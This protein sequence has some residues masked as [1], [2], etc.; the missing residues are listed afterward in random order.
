MFVLK[1]SFENNIEEY[2][3]NLNLL[4]ELQYLKDNWDTKEDS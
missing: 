3:E 1:S 4:F 2:E